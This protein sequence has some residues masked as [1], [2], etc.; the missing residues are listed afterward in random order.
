MLADKGQH[1]G[2]HLGQPAGTAHDAGDSHVVALRVDRGGHVV[3][4]RDI[5]ARIEAQRRRRLERA[6]AAEGQ[7]AGKGAQGGVGIDVQRAA[8]QR[9]ARHSCCCR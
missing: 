8:G 5:A 9:R 6:I 1:A 4:D 3:I 2:P 7:A